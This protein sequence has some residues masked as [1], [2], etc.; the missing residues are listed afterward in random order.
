MVENS[1]TQ[2]SFGLVPQVKIAALD[3]KNVSF[4]TRSASQSGDPR[5]SLLR[6]FTVPA[7]E[8]YTTP[9][10]GAP[11][12]VKMQAGAMGPLYLS[13]EGWK[14]AT[15][16][17]FGIYGA[18]QVPIKYPLEAA[19]PSAP[20]TKLT[21]IPTSIW[22]HGQLQGQGQGSTGF[23]DLELLGKDAQASQDIVWNSADYIELRL[24]EQGV[25]R[26]HLKSHA[27]TVKVWPVKIVI[28]GSPTIDR[29]MVGEVDILDGEMADSAQRFAF[30]KHGSPITLSLTPDGVDAFHVTPQAVVEQSSDTGA[31]LPPSATANPHKHTY[32]ER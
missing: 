32:T 19:I 22:I 28:K 23:F 7:T 12:A 24:T 16:D 4:S 11:A 1:V 31:A 15:S 13:G 3:D 29:A 8:V 20:L 10:P 25:R 14:T 27:T 2:R 9:I 30:A 18:D 26:L 5:E 6:T 21:V 17:G